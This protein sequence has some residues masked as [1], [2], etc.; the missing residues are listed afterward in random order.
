MEKVKLYALS[1][2]YIEKMGYSK[3]VAF[4]SWARSEEEA[5]GLATKK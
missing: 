1:I 5:I 4:Y 3:H 2:F